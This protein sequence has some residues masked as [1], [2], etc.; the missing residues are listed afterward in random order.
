MDGLILLLPQY[1]PILFDRDGRTSEAVI[2]ALRLHLDDPCKIFPLSYRF[3]LLVGQEEL[4]F[5]GTV[6]Y[7]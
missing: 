5:S 7:R 2:N 4:P 6:T 1:V 3:S